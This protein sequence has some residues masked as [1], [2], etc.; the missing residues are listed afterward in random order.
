MG[1]GNSVKITLD[2]KVRPE[3]SVFEVQRGDLEDQDNYYMKMVFAYGISRLNK[4]RLDG[5]GVVELKG[6]DFWT[7]WA[8]PGRSCRLFRKG[9]NGVVVPVSKPS[10]SVYAVYPEDCINYCKSFKPAPGDICRMNNDEFV[11]KF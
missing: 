9:A 8:Q 6:L 3:R 10:S 2:C 4:C 11:K 5:R 7:V 1:V